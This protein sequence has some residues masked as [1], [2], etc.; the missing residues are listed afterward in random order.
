MDRRKK[1]WIAAGVLVLALAGGATAAV[2]GG[3]LGD[4]RPI[5]G[6]SLRKAGAAA[7]EATGGG[8]VTETET[9]DEDGYYEVEVTLDSGR[10]VDV[11]L[12]KDFKVL[13]Q[14]S[15]KESPDDKD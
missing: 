2:A 7:L 15:D 9:G 12:D 6:E 1:V 13:G 3:D 5:T 4:S 14:E 11:A 8:K 10:Q